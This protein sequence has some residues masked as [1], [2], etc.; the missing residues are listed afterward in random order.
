MFAGCACRER[1][2]G[3]LSDCVALVMANI[4][5]AERQPPDQ[6]KRWRWR[7][8]N[9]VRV[10]RATPLASSIRCKPVDEMSRRSGD[11]PLSTKNCPGD[12]GRNRRAIVRFD[13]GGGRAFLA[14]LASPQHLRVQRQPGSCPVLV[15][16]VKVTSRFRPALWAAPWSQEAMRLG[17]K[18]RHESARRASNSL[19][20]AMIGWSNSSTTS[21]ATVCGGRVRT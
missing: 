9:A 6:D 4:P 16:A 17:P 11:L 12:I 1:E 19:P 5:G 20:I 14:V 21:I 15:P 7:C 2:L 10:H 18:S 8:A 13:Q 3:V